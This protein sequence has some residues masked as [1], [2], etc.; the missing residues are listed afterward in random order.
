MCSFVE[1]PEVRAEKLGARALQLE[2]RATLKLPSCRSLP[3]HP[4][5]RRS[6]RRENRLGFAG[7]RV[8]EVKLGRGDRGRSRSGRRRPDAGS[9]PGM[10]TLDPAPTA[11]ES[12][13]C[14]RRSRGAEPS[15]PQRAARSPPSPALGYAWSRSM[16]VMSQHPGS[17]GALPRKRCWWDVRGRSH[18]RRRTLTRCRPCRRASPGSVGSTPRSRPCGKRQGVRPPARVPA[19]P[20]ASTGAR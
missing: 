16:P 4:R 12:R 1:P 14:N 19:D 11:S 10:E 5:S 3:R 7:C 13:P 17:S 2:D 18:R 20:S 15:Q 8:A 6:N 9:A